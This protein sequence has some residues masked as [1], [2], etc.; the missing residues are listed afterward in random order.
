MLRY[1]AIGDHVFRVSPIGV[2]GDFARWTG[3]ATS[4]DD[5]QPESYKDWT[6]WDAEVSLVDFGDYLDSDW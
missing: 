5:T 6:K 1:N 4:T 3:D 2:F